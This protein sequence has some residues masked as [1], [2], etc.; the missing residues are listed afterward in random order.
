MK[1]LY[2]ILLVFILVFSM[3]SISALAEV[4]LIKNGGFE[5]GKTN[6][7]GTGGSA[8]NQVPYISVSSDIKHSGSQSVKISD[9]ASKQPYIYQDIAVTPDTEYTLSFW[10]YT[11]TLADKTAFGFKFEYYQTQN[12]GHI[13]LDDYGRLSVP[14]T[15]YKKWIKYDIDFITPEKCYRVNP[16]IR[17]YGAGTVYVDDVSLVAKGA[18]KRILITN[19]DVF[20]YADN[21]TGEVS[22]RLNTE[23][24]TLSSS[25]KIVFTIL[26][27]NREIH[28][29][30]A[31][32][33]TNGKATYTFPTKDLIKDK[34]Y[35]LSATLYDGNVTESVSQDIYKV[36]RPSMLDKNGTAY[37]DSKPFYPVLAYHVNY[38]NKGELDDMPQMGVNL[39][40]CPYTSPSGAYDYLEAAKKYGV[41]V[42]VPLYNSMLPA[43]H[44]DNIQ[45]TID[46]VNK[47]KDHEALFGYIMID[48]PFGRVH[49]PGKVLTE[50]Y[51]LIRSLDDKHI[52][53][54]V[55]D[56]PQRDA[57]S[58]QYA[59]VLIIDPYIWDKYSPASYVAERTKQA[60]QCGKPIYVL[61]QASDLTYFPEGEEVRSM[62]YQAMLSGAKGAGYYSIYDTTWENGSRV[63]IMNTKLWEPLCAFSSE[64]GKV[65][66]L[67]LENANFSSEVKNGIEIYKWNVDG[68]SYIACRN[69]EWSKGASVDSLARS[70]SIDI[71]KN[72]LALIA[73]SPASPSYEAGVVSL[74]LS[75]C[76]VCVFKVMG[77]PVF[78]QNGLAMEEISSGKIT[79]YNKEK[80]K[81]AIA[82]YVNE[83]NKIKMVDFK[84]ANDKMDIYSFSVPST[85]VNMIRAFFYA[86]NGKILNAE[87]ISL[88]S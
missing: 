24:Y 62:W 15:D 66:P 42:L 19:A 44:P 73:G 18:P 88:N 34:T 69:T 41:K 46:V 56:K 7:I 38:G 13:G 9:N 71:G 55:N 17:L 59:D 29:S 20:N 30:D 35:V 74:T 37:F 49:R 64:I 63:S 83:G 47:V 54:F 28:K 27:G 43:G 21:E 68:E 60:R 14:S 57:E 11:E 4:N 86:E 16:L 25:A 53:T 26:N 80:T 10:A 85:G 2:V 23:A 79:V 36:N 39:V 87:T 67:F 12:G 45:N 84:I 33:P 78:V 81:I 61:V 75:Y 31:V 8:S 76:D 22:V 50:G 48:E 32:I 40:Q 70:V 5:N 1:R 77:V 82:F 58:A 51:K 65:Q 3:G 52:I 72:A 6:W